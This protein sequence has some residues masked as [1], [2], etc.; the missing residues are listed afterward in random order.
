MYSPLATAPVEYQGRELHGADAPTPQAIH[1]W[2]HDYDF[3][4]WF[5]WFGQC[6]IGEPTCYA[7]GW[8][9]GGSKISNGVI[10]CYEQTYEFAGLERGHLV[11]HAAGGSN[12]P[13][14]LV[15]LCRP[16]NLATPMFERAQWDEAT[17]W[18]RDAFDPKGHVP[19]KFTEPVPVVGDDELT[20]TTRWLI[21]VRDLW[22]AGCPEDSWKSRVFVR[23]NGKVRLASGRSVARLRAA[24]AE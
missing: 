11:S 6:D 15:L 3:D 5:H 1:E 24:A 7:C 23:R 17:E 12:H 16:C 14:N 19:V 21:A 4:R 9:D 2:W 22:I 18:V 13:S 20:E 8:Y 10:R